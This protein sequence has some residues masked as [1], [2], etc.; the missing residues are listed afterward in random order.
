MDDV[1]LPTI[2]LILIIA[3]TTWLLVN[4]LKGLK[5]PTDANPLQCG[6]GQCVFNLTTGVKTCPTTG[7]VLIPDPETEGCTFPTTCDDGRSPYA[8]KNDGSTTLGTCD[9][10]VQC[11]CVTNPQ[12]PEYIQSVFVSHNG[13]VFTQDPSTIL[14]QTTDGLPTYTDPST[15]FCTI[16]AQFLEKSSPGCP[17]TSGDLLKDITTCMNS[18]ASCLSGHLAF[19]PSDPN[20]FDPNNTPVGC[21]WG[22]KCSS[23]VA[24]FNKFTGTIMCVNLNVPPTTR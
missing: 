4:T 16:P 17:L 5:H 23:G 19:I 2:T 3:F 8:V 22:T 15:T 1:V 11:R 10:G 7:E 13:S 24:V 18:D 9:P 12:C 20:N 21:V 14:V 6:V